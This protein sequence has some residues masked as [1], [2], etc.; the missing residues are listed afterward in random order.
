MAIILQFIR[1][2]GIGFLNTAVDFSILNFFAASLG[3]YRGL[4]VAG[5]NAVSFAV[6]VLH[7]YWWNKYWAFGRSQGETTLRQN[8]GQFVTAAVLGAGV[9][10]L[11]ILGAGLKY[12]PAFFIGMLVLLVL[13]EVGLW[14]GFK[15]KRDPFAQ[16]SGRE[17]ALFVIISLIGIGIN[18]GIVGGVTQIVEPQFG[19][20]QALWTNLI[21]VLATGVALIWNFLGYK[22]IVFKR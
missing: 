19:L 15:L 4:A 11:V 9:V 2:A 21:K 17:L 20:G 12:G 5:V 6:A 22:L 3:A 1:F 18:S 14:K 16:K 8:I 7:S 10:G 13:G